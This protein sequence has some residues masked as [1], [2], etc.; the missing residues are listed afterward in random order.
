MSQA[1]RV[2][3]FEKITRVAPRV[4]LYPEKALIGHLVQKIWDG[5]SRF[6]VFGQKPLDSIWLGIKKPPQPYG[7][8]KKPRQNQCFCS[9]WVI[10]RSFC[11]HFGLNLFNLL[12]LGFFSKFEIFKDF[13]DEKISNCCVFSHLGSFG[14]ILRSFYSHF[15][16]ILRSFCGP[17]GLNLF[18]LF[19]LVFFSKFEIFKDFLDDKIS[20]CCV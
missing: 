5:T 12:I 10:L 16:V 9:F 8:Q 2:D 1:A 3:K 14:V 7:L 15:T 6:W 13:L 20:K 19:N 4:S 17:F 18:Y 11:G